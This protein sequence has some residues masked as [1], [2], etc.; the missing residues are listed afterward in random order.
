MSIS[1]NSLFHFTGRYILQKI[2]IEAKLR[3]K[4]CKEQIVYVEDTKLNELVVPMISL[5][6]IPLESYVNSSGEKYGY[7]ALGLKKTW[8]FKNGLNPVLYIENTHH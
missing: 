3:G 1:S 2:L 6:D 8:G 7:Y 4:Y 5:C